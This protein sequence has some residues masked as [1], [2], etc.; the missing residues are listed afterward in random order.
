M[1]LQFSP[2]LLVEK[3]L[4]PYLSP[5][6]LSNHRLNSWQGCLCTRPKCFY[7]YLPGKYEGLDPEAT[8]LDNLDFERH[9]GIVIKDMREHPELTF[10]DC[11]F[12]FHHHQSQYKH[13]EKPEDIESYRSETEQMLQ[14]R[15][16]QN[17]LWSTTASEERQT[18]SQ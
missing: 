1:C 15:F 16:G 2:F 3:T 18:Q 14:K 17:G 11:G 6:S 12:E 8:K 4:L 13:F 5:C 10:D 7:L 9:S